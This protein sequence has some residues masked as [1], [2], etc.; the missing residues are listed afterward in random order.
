MDPITFTQSVPHGKWQWSVWKHNDAAKKSYKCPFGIYFAAQDP[1]APNRLRIFNQNGNHLLSKSPI[2]PGQYPFS[3]F[4][5]NEFPSLDIQNEVLKSLKKTNNGRFNFGICC[6]PSD[7]DG[8]S[9]NRSK[10][11]VYLD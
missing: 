2:D 3:D 4:K 11:I 6:G 1:D 9:F 10:N 8:K 5:E 7:S